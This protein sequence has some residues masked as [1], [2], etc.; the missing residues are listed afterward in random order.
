MLIQIYH[1][2]GDVRKGALHLPRETRDLGATLQRIKTV[3]AE[4]SPAWISTLNLLQKELSV[5][6]GSLLDCTGDLTLGR[7]VMIGRGSQILTHDHDHRGR[8]PLL[9]ENKIV[10]KSKIIGDDVWIHGATILM[11]CEYIARGVVIGAG[12]V[13]TK[14]I[15][16]EYSIW[17]GNPARKVGV[18]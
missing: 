1:P 5:S 6:P 14:P 10:W 11:Q 2:H 15:T 4:N 3:G 8:E 7:Y 18:R 12:S 16:E 13:V 9:I 17:A